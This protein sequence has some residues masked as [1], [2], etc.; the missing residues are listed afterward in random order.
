[1]DL[2]QSPLAGPARPRG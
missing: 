1:M 2:Q